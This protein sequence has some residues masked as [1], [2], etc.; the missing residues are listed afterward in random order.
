MESLDE[1]VC[2]LVR[3][4]GGEECWVPRT[5]YLRNPAKGSYV[6]KERKRLAEAQKLPMQ[7]LTVKLRKV[8]A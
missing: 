4:E 7:Y 3:F 6:I 1:V 8:R 5:E 2:V